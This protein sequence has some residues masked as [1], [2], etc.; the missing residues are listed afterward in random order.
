MTIMDTS[1]LYST[2]KNTS[3]AA[4]RFGYIPPHGKRLT[5]NQEVTVLG[6]IMEAVNRGDRGGSRFMNAL[7]DDV[8]AGRLKIVETPNPV[9]YDETL[10]QSSMI[11]IVNDVVTVVDPCWESSVS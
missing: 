6:H 4:M 8:Q 5:A 1:C 2:I 7:I 3:G 11:T 10:H 9:F